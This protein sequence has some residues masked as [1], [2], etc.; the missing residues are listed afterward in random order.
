[1]IELTKIH[2][3][4]AFKFIQTLRRLNLAKEPTGVYRDPADIFNIWNF[5]KKYGVVTDDIKEQE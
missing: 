3:D 2:A 4:A 5:A 1:M